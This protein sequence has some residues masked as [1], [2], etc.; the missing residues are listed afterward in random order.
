MR[1]KEYTYAYKFQKIGYSSINFV[2]VDKEEILKYMQYEVSMTVYM[3]RIANQRKVSKWL[4]FK[5]TSQK[6]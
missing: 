4:P 6:C 3:G 5:T 1:S 2:C